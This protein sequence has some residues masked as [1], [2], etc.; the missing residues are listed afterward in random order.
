M[1]KY[2]FS[3]SKLDRFWIENWI[4]SWVNPG[5]IQ[6]SGLSHYH[7]LF[8]LNVNGTKWLVTA[9]PEIESINFTFSKMKK[10][11]AG[12]E[13]RIKKGWK[14]GT[15]SRFESF[16]ILS[17]S[18]ESKTNRKSNN[19][20]FRFHSISGPKTAIFEIFYS[21]SHT[22]NRYSKVACSKNPIKAP[23]KP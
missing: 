3:E 9:H 13:A 21:D 11:F 14:R 1:Q 17:N 4:F 20:I 10:G 12:K 7:M 23:L 15:E 8:E 19:R 22:I 18:F 5:K 2:P 16:W 6:F